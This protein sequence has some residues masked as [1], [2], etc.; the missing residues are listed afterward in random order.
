MNLVKESL[1]KYSDYTSPIIQAIQIIIIGYLISNVYIITLTELK[2]A[3]MA[4]QLGQMLDP[5]LY[6]PIA[7]SVSKIIN[8]STLLTAL[9]SLTGLVKKNNNPY[10]SYIGNKLGKRPVA[11]FLVFTFLGAYFISIRSLLIASQEIDVQLLVITEWIATCSLFFIGYRSANKY[12]EIYVDHRETVQNWTKHTQE[13][14][15]TTNKKMDNLAALVQDFL[16]DGEK[17][18]LGITLASMMTSYGYSPEK[19]QTVLHDYLE[20]SD[21]EPGLFAFDWQIEYLAQ[22]NRENRREVIT[23]TME[24]LSS[25]EL[26]KE[27]QPEI[28]TMEIIKE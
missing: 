14:K 28:E 15:Y 4:E 26:V 10:L 9:T 11:Q 18:L 7:D 16:E 5:Y 20:Y 2:S 24:R 22:K 8:T 6:S 1:F 17:S 3:R 23:A 27:P 13:I 21:L 19:I 25:L 12:A